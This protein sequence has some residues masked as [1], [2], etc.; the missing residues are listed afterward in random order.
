MSKL[1]RIILPDYC[2]F[3]TTVVK[4]REKILLNEKICSLVLEDLKF[5]RMKYKFKLHG[6]VIMPDHLHLLMS[7]SE[8]GNVS[9]IMHD[10]KSHIAQETNI[11]LKRSGAF[12]QEGFYDHIIR[13]E[14]DFIK[15]VDYIHKNPLTSGLV[16]D[17]SEYQ[18]SS[19][20]NYYMGDDSVIQI[21]RIQW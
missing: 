16:K 2:Y 3:V 20:R 10:F 6:Y 7:L 18:F 1:K 12:W 8:D 19:F 13:D 17:P 11:T 15:K 14:R 5:Y 9:R 21:D 4:D